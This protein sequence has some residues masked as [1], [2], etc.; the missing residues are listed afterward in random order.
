MKILS[1][2]LSDLITE[3]FKSYLCSLL[4]FLAEKVGI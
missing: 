2:L 4:A 3:N 1:K